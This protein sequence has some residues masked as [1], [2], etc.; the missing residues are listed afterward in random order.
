MF[1]L[2]NDIDIYK[3]YCNVYILSIYYYY[4]D[5]SSFANFVILRE[6]TFLGYIEL[7][8]ELIKKKIKIKTFQKHFSAYL[9][10]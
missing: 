8:D 2:H 10:G 4:I 3:I 7:P 6:Q 5:F 1:F 9:W